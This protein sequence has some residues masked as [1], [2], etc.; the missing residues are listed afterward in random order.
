MGVA[1]ILAAKERGGIEI[2]DR[3]PLRQAGGQVGVGDKRTSESDEVSVTALK[4]PIG[5]L[6]IVFAGHDDRAAEAHPSG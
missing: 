4:H 1:V 2:G 5:A 6:D 3:K